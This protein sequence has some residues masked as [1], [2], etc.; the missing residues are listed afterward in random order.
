MRLSASF[1]VMGSGGLT[2]PKNP[3]VHG[4]KD[5]DGEVI[6]QAVGLRKD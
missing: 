6:Q 2:V 4:I 3:E 5:F 1:L